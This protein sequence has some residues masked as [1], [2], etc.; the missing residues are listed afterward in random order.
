[1]LCFLDEEVVLMPGVSQQK[2]CKQDI[3]FATTAE[4]CYYEKIT[5]VACGHD[6]KRLIQHC[7][8]AR[9]DPGRQCFG[10]W[11]YKRQWNQYSSKCGN[12]IELEQYKLASGQVRDSQSSHSTASAR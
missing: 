6:E 10:A 5:F 7:H 12:C 11:R 2:T 1:M 9:N 4:M 3:H 8:F